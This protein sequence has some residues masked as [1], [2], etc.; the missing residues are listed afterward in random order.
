MSISPST[1]NAQSD[2]YSLSPSRGFEAAFHAISY[3]SDP[4]EQEKKDTSAPTITGAPT[5][6]RTALP[7]IKLLEEIDHLASQTLIL[8][9]RAEELQKDLVKLYGKRVR[10]SKSN[11]VIE[12]ATNVWGLNDGD[13]V[14]P[15][16]FARIAVARMAVGNY[17]LTEMNM[18]WLETVKV[19]GRKH[20]TSAC[21]YKQ[22]HPTFYKTDKTYRKFYDKF[23]EALS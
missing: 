23:I 13:I 3:S 8:R 22:N 18:S 17:L 5:H 2:S 14:G 16:R 9:Q 10:K 7:I 11:V 1:E 15:S 19:L 4:S 6:G 12:V 20:H 21:Q